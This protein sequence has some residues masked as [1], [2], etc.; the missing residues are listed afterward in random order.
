MRIDKLIK[1]WIIGTL[2]EEVLRQVV[3][4]NTATDVWDALKNTFDKATMDREL[5]LHHLLE[6]VKRESCKS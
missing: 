3:G 4:L 2:S 6:V 1:G 5:T